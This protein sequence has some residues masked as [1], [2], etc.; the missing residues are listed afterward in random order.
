MALNSFRGAGNLIEKG[1][2]LFFL[3]R[4]HNRHGAA[5]ML[6]QHP[7]HHIGNGIAPIDLFLP[8]KYFPFNVFDQRP[9]I[10]LGIFQERK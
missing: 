8:R 10:E 7:G 4:F 5:R 9:Y 3:V 1:G 2:H 6:V